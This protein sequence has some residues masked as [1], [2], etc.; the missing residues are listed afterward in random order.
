MADAR[1]AGARESESFAPESDSMADGRWQPA[2]KQDLAIVVGDDTS[3]W[4]NLYS[5][6]IVKSL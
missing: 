4:A 5:G 3:A 2:V 6:D 1:V